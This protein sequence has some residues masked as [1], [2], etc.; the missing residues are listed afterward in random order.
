ISCPTLLTLSLAGQSHI[1]LLA[2]S[3]QTLDTSTLLF[4]QE[5]HGTICRPSVLNAY[6]LIPVSDALEFHRYQNW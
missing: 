3:T 4:L 5:T 1:L 2:F 6:M